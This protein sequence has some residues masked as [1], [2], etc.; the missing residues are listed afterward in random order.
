MLLDV[1][2]DTDATVADRTYVLTI[3]FGTGFGTD[4]GSNLTEGEAYPVTL[5]QSF[6]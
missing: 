3:E 4:L 1:P 6:D 5:T 2:F